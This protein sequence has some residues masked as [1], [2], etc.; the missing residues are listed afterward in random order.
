M[1]MVHAQVQDGPQD[2]GCWGVARHSGVEATGPGKKRLRRRMGGQC[3][4]M[5]PKTATI[6]PL[7]LP[8]RL[9]HIRPGNE[10]N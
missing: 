9:V 10:W 8:P 1:E 6:L 5:A 3:T 4:A 2:W 7:L